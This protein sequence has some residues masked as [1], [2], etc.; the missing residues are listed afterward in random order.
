LFWKNGT[1]HELIGVR[2]RPILFS[3]GF[4]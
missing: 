1:R 2:D 4:Q 3:R